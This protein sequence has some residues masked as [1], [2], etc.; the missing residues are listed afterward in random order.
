MCRLVEFEC[1]RVLRLYC[2]CRGVVG[3][4]PDGGRLFIWCGV[5]QSDRDVWRQAF[6]GRAKRT[7]DVIFNV[8]LSWAYIILGG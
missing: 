8:L 4:G 7:D 1:P 6:F 3:T 5:V 2:T